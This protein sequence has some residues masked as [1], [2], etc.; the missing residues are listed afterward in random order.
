VI[1]AEIVGVNIEPSETEIPAMI[2][3]NVTTLSRNRCRKQIVIDINDSANKVVGCS[4]SL[5]RLVCR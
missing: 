1:D 5:A 4:S 3:H 2:A